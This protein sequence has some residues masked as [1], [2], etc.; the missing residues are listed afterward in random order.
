MKESKLDQAERIKA[1]GRAERSVAKMS[2]GIFMTEDYYLKTRLNFV[3]KRI[4]ELTKEIS[5][6]D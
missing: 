3:R 5:S 2:L 4:K 6:G 1:E